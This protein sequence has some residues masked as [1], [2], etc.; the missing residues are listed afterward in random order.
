MKNKILVQCCVCGQTKVD[1]KYDGIK[2][3]VVRVGN[4]SHGYCPECFKNAM[5]EIKN[6]E[7]K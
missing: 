1:G 2:K 6:L 3:E 7:S 5:E 4:V